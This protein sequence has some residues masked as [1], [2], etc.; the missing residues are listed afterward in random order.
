[1]GRSQDER[2]ARKQSIAT[3]VISVGLFEVYWICILS[4]KSIH[5]CR[6]LSPF[7]LYPSISKS[8]Y[9]NWICY[10]LP[11]MLVIFTAI[12]SPQIDE[13]SEARVVVET[14]WNYPKN[15]YAY[16][17]S[18]WTQTRLLKVKV[19][20]G[21]D[22]GEKVGEMGNICN[23][24]NNN[25]L[26]LLFRKTNILYMEKVMFSMFSFPIPRHKQ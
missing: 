21:L 13:I 6:E 20:W 11:C 9:L 4:M 1:M 10:I 8:I 17:H 12:L 22:G 14:G 15:F 23:T 3:I 16:I 24:I 19:G 5:F 18:P 7:S 25:F 2:R 26:K